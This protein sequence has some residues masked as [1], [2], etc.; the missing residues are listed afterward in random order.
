MAPEVIRGSFNVPRGFGDFGQIKKKPC[1]W[2]CDLILMFSPI[3]PSRHWVGILQTLHSFIL[4]SRP[5]VVSG[6]WG[7]P[8]V[9]SRHRTLQ[10]KL[11]T[12][13]EKALFPNKI[14]QT[15]FL[16]PVSH[17]RGLFHYHYEKMYMI[18]HDFSIVIR[19]H[20]PENPD[21]TFWLG[22]SEP[23]GTPTDF[24]RYRSS[25]LHG[26]IFHLERPHAT[27]FGW[28]PWLKRDS[29]LIDMSI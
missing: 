4:E 12:F 6:P 17:F 11:D 10:C 26:H 14:L 23:I 8:E 25:L 24:H 29:H 5:P 27:I 2:Q 20:I 9:C 19:V 13:F 22:I 7:P 28:M 16:N 18:Y 21:V 3:S 15:S 1:I